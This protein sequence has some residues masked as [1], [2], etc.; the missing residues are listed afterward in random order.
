MSADRSIL[1][2]A[3]YTATDTFNKGYELQNILTT[4]RG[5]HAL[6]VGF[7]ARQSDTASLTNANF[8]GTYI[9]NP[10][11]GASTACPGTL[12]ALDACTSRPSWARPDADPASF[13]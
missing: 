7:R 6:K 1:G 12:T 4:T 5:K 11:I 13:R 8:N 10:P 9:F 3:P 2:G